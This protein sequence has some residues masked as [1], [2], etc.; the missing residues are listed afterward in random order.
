MHCPVPLQATEPRHRVLQR[1]STSSRRKKKKVHHFQLAQVIPHDGLEAALTVFVELQRQNV[2]KGDSSENSQQHD[3]SS[4][5]PFTFCGRSQSSLR[6]PWLFPNPQACQNVYG[7]HSAFCLYFAHSIHNLVVDIRWET[8]SVAKLRPVFPLKLKGHEDN[9][10][11]IDLRVC[12]IKAICL[13]SR[14]CGCT[15]FATQS[16]SRSRTTVCDPR[17]QMPFPH[18]V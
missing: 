13:T 3:V 9:L 2:Y 11:T 6:I 18:A 16:D 12:P 10:R 5:H 8:S 4:V 17:C 1:R 14:H 15:M 7:P